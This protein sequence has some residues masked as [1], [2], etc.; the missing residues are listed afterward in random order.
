MKVS[1]FTP[2][3]GG[4]STLRVICFW[5]LLTFGRSLLDRVDL[6]VS[7]SFDIVVVCC[8]AGAFTPHDVTFEHCK[9]G[10]FSRNSPPV[11]STTSLPW[12]P[13]AML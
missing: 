7:R 8:R 13:R 5:S 6:L 4:F 3:N 9:R 10:L 11:S 1:N 2:A 12:T